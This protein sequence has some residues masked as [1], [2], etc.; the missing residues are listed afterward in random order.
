M[1]SILLKNCFYVFR[2][3]AEAALSGTDILIRGNRIEKIEPR[4]TLP[5]ERAIDCSQHVVIPGLIDRKS[6]V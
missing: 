6:V 4:I 1:N 3:A 2:S 5:A